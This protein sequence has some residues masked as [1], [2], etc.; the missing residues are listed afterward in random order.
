LRFCGVSAVASRPERITSPVSGHSSPATIR[1]SVDLPE[2]LGPR[3]AVSEPPST[4]SDTSSRA[5]NSPKRFVMLLIWM[6]I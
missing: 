1:R 6:D 4:S 2:P 5:T 3:R